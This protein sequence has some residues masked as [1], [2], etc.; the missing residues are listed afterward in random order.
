MADVS[1][2]W[3]IDPAELIL[4]EELVEVTDI[5]FHCF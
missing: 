1:D 5:F 4:L 2:K 3:E